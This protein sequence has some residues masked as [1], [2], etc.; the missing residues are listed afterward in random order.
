[1]QT[2]EKSENIRQ[3]ILL[4]SEEEQDLK[5]YAALEHRSKQSMAGIIYRLGLQKYL[6]SKKPVKKC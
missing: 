2:S 6:Q 5:Q 1:M 4:N 3:P